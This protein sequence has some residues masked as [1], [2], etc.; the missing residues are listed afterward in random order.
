MNLIV[1]YIWGDK[2]TFS[3]PHKLYLDS[4]SKIDCYKLVIV[5]D[6]S[7]ENIDRLKEI[8]NHVEV[9]E[10]PDFHY[11][12]S[13]V[14]YKTIERYQSL[15]KYV[16]FTDSYD[17]IFQSDPFEYISKFENEIFLTSPGFKVNEQWP[18]RNWQ[19]YF[20]KSVGVSLDFNEDKV[21]N[22]GIIAGK[23]DSILNFYA[24][25]ASNL[26]RNGCHIVD[27][28][29]FLYFAQLM[30]DRDTIKIFDTR[31]DNFIYH[32]QNEYFFNRE[33]KPNVIDGKIYTQ[34]GQL[35]C[36]WHQWDDIG[37]EA[38]LDDDGQVYIK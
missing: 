13:Y 29:V 32:C 6:M 5:Y 17:V 33:E 24:F 26:N 38:Y 3:L 36:I 10:K 31:S 34:D 30:K 11:T 9:I 12:S 7:D 2:Y 28:T 4:L 20:N 35:Y 27:Q 37:Y 19:E 18:D 16:L 14:I 1:N 21:L 25:V 23:I 8:Y 22:G 15:C